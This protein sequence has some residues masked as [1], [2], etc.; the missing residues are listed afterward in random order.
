MKKK[1]KKEEEEEEERL[2]E[3]KS[4]EIEARA[5]GMCCAG[6]IRHTHNKKMRRDVTGILSASENERHCTHTA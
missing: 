4:R 3:R 2:Q 5:E 1:K 6:G